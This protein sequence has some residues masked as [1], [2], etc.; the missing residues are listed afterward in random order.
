MKKTNNKENTF[1]VEPITLRYLHRPKNEEEAKEMAGGKGGFTC[2]FCNKEKYMTG[3]VRDA[4]SISPKMICRDCAISQFKE[5]SGYSSTEEAVIMRDRLFDISHKLNESLYERLCYE[6]DI[7]PREEDPDTFEKACM[8]GNS[9]W[10][11]FPKEFKEGLENIKD[12]RALENIASDMARDAFEDFIDF[13][14]EEEKAKK[15]K[16]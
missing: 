11:T 6:Q 2:D 15:K 9:F 8:L 4:H 14:E 1:P 7:D 16:R 3:G 5:E 13:V 10:N 12:S